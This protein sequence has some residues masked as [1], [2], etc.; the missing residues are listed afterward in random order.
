MAVIYVCKMQRMHNVFIHCSFAT[1][2]W[3]AVFQLFGI[4]C[5]MQGTVK[6]LFEHWKYGFSSYRGKVVWKRLLV[7]TLWNVMAR[8]KPP[9][10]QRSKEMYSAGCEHDFFLKFLYGQPSV[11]NLKVILLLTFLDPG[12][13]FLRMV[14]K[15]FDAILCGFPLLKVF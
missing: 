5:M 12:D 9:D 11:R 3:H 15:G 13:L 7:A 8:K 6:D 2:V 1:K 14:A 10:F 4:D